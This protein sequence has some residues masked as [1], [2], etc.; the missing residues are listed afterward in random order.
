MMR[1]A[2][3]R[4]VLGGLCVAFGV[5]VG[6]IVG[7]HLISFSV[8]IDYDSGRIRNR[9]AYGTT[10][11]LE[12]E[13]RETFA[14][15]PIGPE[16][17]GRS[18]ARWKK[19]LEYRLPYRVS[20]YFEAGDVL[21]ASRALGSLMPRVCPGMAAQTKTTFLRTLRDSGPG[22]AKAFAQS[23]LERMLDEVQRLQ[24]GGGCP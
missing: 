21:Q 9:I 13:V 4:W 5:A 8:D 22:A 16:A 20:P 17:N 12:I 19:A 23:E 1:F 14:S 11:L 7:S 15:F 2:R 3:S 18:G 10:S 6:L 24:E